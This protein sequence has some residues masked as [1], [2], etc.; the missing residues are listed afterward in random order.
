MEIKMDDLTLKRHVEE[1]LEWEPSLDSADIGVGVEDGVVTLMGH[2]RTFAEKLAAEGAVK[3]VKGV[4]ALAQNME[5]RL[6]GIPATTDDELARRAADI[7]E[8]DV[9]VPKGAI[10]AKVEGG[11]I[12]LTGTV[13]WKY[14]SDAAKFRLSNLPGVK[15]VV[16]LV[17]VKAKPAPADIR[18]R[19]EKALMRN[20][21]TEA[22][23][24][25]VTVDQG[26]V[27]LKGNID[28][29]HDREIAEQAAWSAPG[30][31]A[32]DDQLR[33]V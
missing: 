24:I 19:I 3:R 11:H 33:L 21:Q 12:T 18:A 20:A 7:L 5:V 29:W 15:A 27:T 14:Q 25:S 28:A 1:E 6:S 16:N 23:G 8:W 9:S 2:V 30:V 31:V 13:N 32:V 17:K 22:K 4:R 26:R 10:Q